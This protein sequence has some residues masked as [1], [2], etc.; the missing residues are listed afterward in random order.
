MPP[1]I[2]VDMTYADSISGSMTGA[3]HALLPSSSP[4]ASRAGAAASSARST[5]LA[6]AASS[7]SSAGGT[8]VQTRGQ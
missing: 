1:V 8:S 5:P 7:A 6:A 3:P 4:Y 2:D